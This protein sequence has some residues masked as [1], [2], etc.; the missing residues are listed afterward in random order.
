MPPENAGSDLF[1]ACQ[2]LFGR[3]V[4]LSSSFLT[5]LR[6]DALKSTFRERAFLTHPDR[7]SVLGRDPS[8]M[9]REF[10]RVVAAYQVLSAHLQ[11]RPPS[12]SRS[13]PP[14]PARPAPAREGKAPRRGAPASAPSGSRRG[15]GKASTSAPS[16]SSWRGSAPHRTTGDRPVSRTWKGPL[17][18]RCLKLGQFLFFS[19]VIPARDLLDAIAWQRRQRPVFG[20]IARELGILDSRQI[21]HVLARK[22]P[23]EA[24]GECAT[25]LGYMTS[26]E[27]HA[28]AC[29]QKNLQRPFGRY[30]MEKGILDPAAMESA[31][32]LQR[33]HNQAFLR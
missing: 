26:F 17:P 15:A 30:F 11:R 8:Q 23:D 31:L 25:R 14:R 32:L 10:H 13:V 3:K 18:R 4:S 21:A 9:E 7:A 29:R 28:V 22:L 19:G 5:S 24:F 16:A 2:V 1:T 33:A 27:M 6:T 20:R 12:R